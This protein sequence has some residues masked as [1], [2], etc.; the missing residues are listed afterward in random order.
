MSKGRRNIS[1]PWNLD[2]WSPTRRCNLSNRPQSMGTSGQNEFQPSCNISPHPCWVPS[3]RNPAWTRNRNVVGARSSL[4]N[5]CPSIPVGRNFYSSY[6][7]FA[8]GDNFINI[9][10]QLFCMKVFFEASLYLEFVF[11]IFWRGY[12]LKSCFKKWPKLTP[13]VNFIKKF[14]ATFSYKS[15]KRSFSV[16]MF[17]Y[18]FL[19]DCYELLLIYNAVPQ[20]ESKLSLRSCNV[21]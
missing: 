18:V 15:T 11:E 4:D 6:I 20:K 17:V 14:W 7:L 16:I 21:D 1:L 2:S 12:L 19:S 9:L 13:G 3:G 10:Q 5:R 8:P